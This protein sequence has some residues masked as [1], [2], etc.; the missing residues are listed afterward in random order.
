MPSRGSLAALYQSLN[1]EPPPERSL[2]IF[3][4]I[5]P[6]FNVCAVG[7]D[8]MAPLLRAGEVAVFDETDFLPQDDE[9]FVIEQGRRSFGSLRST[10][11]TRRIAQIFR[12]EWRGRECW[13]LLPAYKPQLTDNRDTWNRRRVRNCSD[14]PFTDEELMNRLIGRVVGIFQAVEVG[15]AHI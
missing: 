6:G 12:T 1:L 2:R 7:E 10:P 11:S 13:W 4:K 3:E 14:G 15:N 8:R 5:P 9:L